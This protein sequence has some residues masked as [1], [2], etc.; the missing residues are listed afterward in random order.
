MI[1]SGQAIKA[2]K[3]LRNAVLRLRMNS[4]CLTPIHADFLQVC[5]LSKCYS[6]AVP[7]LDEDIYEVNP[8]QTGTTPRDFM[9]YYYYGGLVY[10]G[11]KN[12]ERAFKFFRTVR[13]MLLSLKTSARSSLPLQLCSVQ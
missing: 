8:D 5:I 4:E 9:L 2:V 13:S 10:T 1:E 11:V 6:V 3:P 12:F 7:L